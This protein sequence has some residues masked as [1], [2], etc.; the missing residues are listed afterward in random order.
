MLR[1]IAIIFG[2]LVLTCLVVLATVGLVAYGQDYSYSFSQHRVVRSGN[3]IIQSIPSGVKIAQ[4]THKPSKKSMY[5]LEAGSTYAFSIVK[6]GYHTWQKTLSVLAGRVSLVQYVILVP[7]DLSPHTLLSNP[8]IVSQSWSRDHR[9]L[10]YVTGG[11]NSA[12]YTYNPG[13][14]KP[15]KIFVPTA[16]TDTTTAETLQTVAWSDDASHLLVTSQLNGVSTVRLMDSSGANAIDLT[17]TYG[18]DFTSLHFS[19]STWKQLYW[20]SPDGL[21]R[22]DVDAQTVS[23]VLA[24]QVKQFSVSGDRVFYIQSANAVESLW[25][26][27]GSG[28]K[29]QQLVAALPTSDHFGMAYVSYR[30]SDVLALVPSVTGA[31]TL[32]SDIFG[33]TPVAQTVAHNVTDVSFSPDG[34]LAAFSGTGTITTYDL[35]QSNVF[36]T[37]VDYTFSVNNMA[38]P[39]VWFDNFHLL[40]SQNGRLVWSEFD[41]QNQVDLGTTAN[42]LPASSSDTKSVYVWRPGTDQTLTSLLIKH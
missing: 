41:G 36:G 33:D 31:G 30:G 6:D 5:R 9:H 40:S 8:Q 27:N 35:D 26:L 23:G 39:P 11:T 18:F 3:V 15:A 21:R 12:I 24:D 20:I 34:H 4:G 10:A 22:L 13:D 29:P 38:T 25:L 19:G 7:T 32:Y 17:S 16:A 2:Y 42:L 14:A 28:N 1:R 37:P